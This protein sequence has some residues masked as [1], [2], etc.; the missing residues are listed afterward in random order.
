MIAICKIIELAYATITY[1]Y[2]A[3]RQTGMINEIGYI[4]V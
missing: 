1:I 4:A 3:R 2:A